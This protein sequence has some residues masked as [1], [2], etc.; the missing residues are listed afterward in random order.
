MEPMG[1]E[2]I[3]YLSTGS[4]QIVCRTQETGITE[5]VDSVLD[6]FIDLDKVHYFD[7]STSCAY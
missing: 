1:S 2:T 4:T 3:L 5:K 7:K 6:V